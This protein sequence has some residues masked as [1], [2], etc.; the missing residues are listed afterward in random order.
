[1]IM[2]LSKFG[3]LEETRKLFDD[4]G[5]RDEISWRTIIGGYIKT[6]CYKEFLQIFNER[7]KD[8][9]RLKKHFS[10]R[11]LFACSELCAFD[12]SRWIHGYLR[13]NSVYL[14]EVLGAA[15]VDVYAKCGRLDLAWHVFED[16]KVKDVS[17]WNA[18]IGGLVIRGHVDNDAIELFLKM[19]RENMRSGMV[20]RGVKFLYSM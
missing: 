12:Q 18:V 4:M 16:M 10:L 3:R 14:D 17:S 2:G 11:V 15:L 6:R 1:M 13:K 20:D 5:E 7:Q 9:T 19:Q 8:Q